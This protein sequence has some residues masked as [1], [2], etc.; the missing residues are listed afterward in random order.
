MSVCKRN[1]LHR[2]TVTIAYF[3]LSLNTANLHGNAYFNCFLSAVVEMPAYTLS[4]VMFR[5]CSRR[6]SLSS[7]LFMGGIFLLLIQL[8]PAGLT[9]QWASFKNTVTQTHAK[10]EMFCHLYIIFPADLVSLSITLEMTGKFAVTTAF[11]I[12]YAYTA[13]LYPTVLRNTALG[14]CSMASRI[15]SI[16]APYFI[17][18][19]KKDISSASS[20]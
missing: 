16:T 19:S 3:A 15:G 5:W 4:W 11:A 2:N 7:A 9:L 8:I 14:A 6:L 12:V 20:I 17:Y 18:L 10:L 13:E 1:D